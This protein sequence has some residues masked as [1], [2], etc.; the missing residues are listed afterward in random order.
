[1]AIS[2]VH[3]DRAKLSDAEVLSAAHDLVNQFL[4]L[5]RREQIGS[6][7]LETSLLPVSKASLENAFRLLIA[8]ELRAQVR[9]RLMSA[10]TALAQF[11]PDIDMRLSVRPSGRPF[12]KPVRRPENPGRQSASPSRSRQLELALARM[13]SDIERLRIMFAEAEVIALRR[14]DP[15]RIKPPF[16][17]DGTYTWHGHH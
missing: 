7:I 17:E 8:T 4:E 2:N 1:M 5:I 9:Q 10:G 3:R 16:A 12:D 11:Q 15:S 13:A 6:D 14:L